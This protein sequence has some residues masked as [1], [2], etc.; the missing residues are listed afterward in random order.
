MDV[1]TD[2]DTQRTGS[3]GSIV[4]GL[5]SL[6]NETDDFG[7]KLL[8]QAKDER[9]LHNAIKNPQPFRKARPS[10]RVALTLENLE[11][12]QSNNTPPQANPPLSNG[13]KRSQSPASSEQSDPPVTIPKEWGR[14]AKRDTEWLSRIKTAN[15]L[16]DSE[17]W[18]HGD[19]IYPYKT[20]FTG[21]GSPRSVDWAAAAADVPVP[22]VEDTPSSMAKMRQQSISPASIRQRATSQERMQEW[23]M[24]DDFTVG[25]LLT[26]TPAVP[27]RSK[28]LDEVRQ[29]EIEI[30]NRRGLASSRL[31]QIREQSP[32]S[33][34]RPSTAKSFPE[35]EASNVTS[36]A[37]DFSMAP[38]PGYP[39]DERGSPRT[40]L[41]TAEAT[42]TA[43][44]PHK[45]PSTESLRSARHSVPPSTALA[46]RFAQLT[47]DKQ[48]SRP[49][50]Q[51]NGSRDLLSAQLADSISKLK[52]ESRAKRPDHERKDSRELLRQLAR[53][54]SASPSPGRNVSSPMQVA[55]EER[56]PSP[57]SD[58]PSENAENIPTPYAENERHLV[59]AKSNN[60]PNETVN[61]NP[62]NGNAENTSNPKV[63]SDKDP[64]PAQSNSISN[65]ITDDNQVEPGHIDP[66]SLRQAETGTLLKTPRVTGAWV[67]T[68]GTRKSTRISLSSWTSSLVPRNLFRSRTKSTV[69]STS[70]DASVEVAP[71]RQE[72]QD[73]RP[74]SI[75]PSSALAAILEDARHI[76]RDENPIR[77]TPGPVSADSANDSD[78][79]TSGQP[80]VK[81]DADMLGDSTI[82]SLEDIIDPGLDYTD[83][84][85]LPNPIDVELRDLQDA[86]SVRQLTQAER[87][88]RDE[89]ILLRSMNSNLRNAK[90]T[91]KDAKRG[92][93]RVERHFG[94]PEHFGATGHQL[95]IYT[96]MDTS[97]F[98]KSSHWFVYTSGTGV[99]QSCPA[100]LPHA[101][102]HAVP[103][104][105]QLVTEF[106]SLFWTWDPP[107]ADH[108]PTLSRPLPGLNLTRLGRLT[109]YFLVW[110]LL[111]LLAAALTPHL[112]ALFSPSPS[113]SFSNSFSPTTTS[114]YYYHAPTSYYDLNLSPPNAPIFPLALP[115]LLLRP[116][117]TTFLQPW[118]AVWGPA[119]YPLYDWAAWWAAALDGER[120]WWW[121]ERVTG[122]GDT[123]PELVWRRWKMVERAERWRGK[124]E[125]PGWGAIRRVGRSEKRAIEEKRVREEVRD[126]EGLEGVLREGR[127]VGRIGDDEVVGGEGGW[128][129]RVRE[130]M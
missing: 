56:K 6:E 19:T 31:D 54:T 82:G 60:A 105:Q 112:Y 113:T 66:N 36:R 30:L 77:S 2:D 27:G 72:K 7:R 71:T 35:N 70:E 61:D 106:R 4:S 119:V 91:I 59:P 97:A 10:T 50:P 9:R 111:E 1:P 92:L 47:R 62:D 128:L 81:L 3:A 63:E 33:A 95:P 114:Y 42:P 121:R 130:M 29:R 55:R 39:S 26:S 17:D 85:E 78:G 49:S 96:G 41:E 93:T 100:T 22:S 94:V 125:Q 84:L 34:R 79:E 83:T 88:R 110:L 23:E 65:E 13:H 124:G 14:K 58:K 25:S 108:W 117:Y 52:S 46:D 8:Q 5:T 98:N 122:W 37:E 21:D 109:L 48:S 53:V 89:M 129:K 103:S 101:H 20:T 38:V 87:E 80:P 118:D 123:L 51:R 32:E 116:L 11:R 120:E 44:I 73:A 67:D 90:T 64:V 24:S 45:T 115:T 69:R 127:G 126:G 68:P 18:Q 102:L 104:S 74:K 99:C 43:K 12:N 28:V 107:S 75:R 76:T 16:V 40:G 86:Q 57:L 15:E